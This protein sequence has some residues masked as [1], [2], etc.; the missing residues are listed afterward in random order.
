MENPYS[1]RPQPSNTAA[2]FAAEF[3]TPAEV[4]LSISYPASSIF[5]DGVVDYFPKRLLFLKVIILKGH[6]SIRLLFPILE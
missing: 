6:Y 1:C 4:G 2:E 3:Y 5:N